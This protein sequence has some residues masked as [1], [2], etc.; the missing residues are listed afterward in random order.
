MSAMEQ[1]A[2]VS[3]LFDVDAQKLLESKQR[4][5]LHTRLMLETQQVIDFVNAQETNDE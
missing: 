1:A 3:A 2:G 5:E 4:L